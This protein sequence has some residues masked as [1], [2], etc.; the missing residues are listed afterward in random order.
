MNQQALTD[1]ACAAQHYP[2]NI[3]PNNYY[4]VSIDDMVRRQTISSF[5][6]IINSN[7]QMNT[8]DVIN[9][10][11]KDLNN[12]RKSFEEKKKSKSLK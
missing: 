4:H 2:H 10:S 1:S 8:K 9:F 5:H 11:Q 12:A 6:N 3:I 7:N